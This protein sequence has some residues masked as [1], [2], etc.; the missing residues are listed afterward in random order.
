MIKT[1]V[2][3]DRCA[4]EVNYPIETPIRIYLTRK[5]E[6]IDLCQSCIDDLNKWFCDEHKENIDDAE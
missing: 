3:C 6:R 5:N 1:T 4:K 2:Y